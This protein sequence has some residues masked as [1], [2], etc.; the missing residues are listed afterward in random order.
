MLA[1]HPDLD[2]AIGIDTHNDTHT[3]AAVGAT[4]AVLEHLTVPASLLPPADRPSGGATARGCGPSR[5]PA[6]SVPD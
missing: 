1:L 6:A 5:A 3:A 4:G 2:V